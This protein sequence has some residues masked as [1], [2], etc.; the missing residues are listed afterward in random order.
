ML[1]D[2]SRHC[3]SRPARRKM[4]H[5]AFPFLEFIFHLN[6]QAEEKIK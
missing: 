5:K 6:F 1:E 2:E 4:T 3:R